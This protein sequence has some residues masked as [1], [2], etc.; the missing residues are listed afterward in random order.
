MNITNHQAPSAE[1][2]TFCIS[3]LATIPL[4]YLTHMVITAELL[5]GFFNSVMRLSKLVALYGE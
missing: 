5:R 2:G 3:R 1:F 4:L